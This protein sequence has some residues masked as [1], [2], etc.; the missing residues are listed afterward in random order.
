VAQQ[1]FAEKVTRPLALGVYSSKFTRISV[2]E[3]SR[4]ALINYCQTAANHPRSLPGVLKLS[5]LP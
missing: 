3:V 2:R 5:H 4:D 1:T